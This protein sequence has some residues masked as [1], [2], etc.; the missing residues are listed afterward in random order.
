[1]T[2][3]KTEINTLSK[4]VLE[5]HYTKYWAENWTKMSK[6]RRHAVTNEKKHS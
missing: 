5:T 1:M 4:Q 6:R 3:T 2:A